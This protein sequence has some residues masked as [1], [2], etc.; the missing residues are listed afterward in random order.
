MV[1]CSTYEEFCFLV[2]TM[3][4]DWWLFHCIWTVCLGVT[5]VALFYGSVSKLVSGQPCPDDL[6]PQHIQVIFLHS[7]ITQMGQKIWPNSICYLHLLP[8]YNHSSE[9]FVNCLPKLWFNSV[10][11]Y[12][13]WL[14]KCFWG[15]ATY[16]IRQPN[17][18]IQ[19]KLILLMH[20]HFLA[21]FTI[22]ILF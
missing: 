1:L 9:F 2:S 16:G 8:Q 11:T 19:D 17:K 20:F 6:F 12:V 7:T 13:L 18:E 5:S 22:V 14:I 21:H 4:T 15:C 3:F 10:S